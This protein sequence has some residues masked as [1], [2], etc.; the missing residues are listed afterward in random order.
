MEAIFIFLTNSSME[1]LRG[2]MA[3][4][5]KE[6]RSGIHFMFPKTEKAY[7]LR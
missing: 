2:G 3:A 5:E 1:G 4:I 6:V 7:L